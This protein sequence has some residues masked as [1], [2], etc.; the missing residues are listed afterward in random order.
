MSGQRL[1]L[2][3]IYTYP[4]QKVVVELVIGPDGKITRISQIPDSFALRAEVE[5]RQNGT[6][7]ISGRGYTTAQGL[8][9]DWE[10]GDLVEVYG[11]GDEIIYAELVEKAGTLHVTA[12]VEGAKVYI[13]GA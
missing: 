12:N 4:Q 13:D 2:E 7:N 8:S 10:Q 6:V 5:G 1:A 3:D 9:F 11:A